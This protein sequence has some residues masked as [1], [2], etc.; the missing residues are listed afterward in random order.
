MSTEGAQLSH[1]PTMRR[2]SSAQNLLSSFKPNSQSSSAPS[3]SSPSPVPTPIPIP[4]P[5]PQTATHGSFAG[6]QTPTATSF[7]PTPTARE[8][9]VQSMHSDSVSGAG[10]NA[11]QAASIEYLRDLVQKRIITLTYVRNVHDGRS[12]WFHTIMVS[13]SELDRVFS[14]AAMKKRTTR[15]ATL[16]MSLSTLFDIHHPPD[17]LRAIISTLQEYEQA[18]EDGERPIN[19]MR[20]WKRPP[21][22]HANGMSMGDYSMAMTPDASDTSYLLTPH[23]PFPLSY[24]QTLLSLLDILSETYHKL[25]KL[26][27]PSAFPHASQHILGLSPHPGVSYLFSG[28][29]AAPVG[30]SDGLW[31][32][33]NGSA[34]APGGMGSPPPS[35]TPALGEMMLKIDGKFKKIISLL[36][37]DLDAFARNGIKDELASLDPLLRRMGGAPGSSFGIGDA[38]RA[39]Y[40]FES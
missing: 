22:R 28:E 2:K 10:G 34:P 9:D 30:E 25:S 14:D 18:K 24:S 16:G 15:F 11:P 4:P 35:W 33:A 12:H 7:T 21:K 20:I 23:F 40:D 26:L 31:G 5:P 8:W 1:R 39:V 17:L 27:G 32:V 3:T 29:G 19:R 38:G 6:V 13:R 37:K 36:L